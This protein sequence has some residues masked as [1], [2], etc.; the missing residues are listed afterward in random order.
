MLRQTRSTDFVLIHFAFKG[1]CKI[2]CKLANMDNHLNSNK[3][4]KN[5]AGDICEFHL[6]QHHHTKDAYVFA[7]VLSIT[8]IT[9]T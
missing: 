6:G 3:V 7:S 2:Y 9:L 5:D 4:F 1:G 8:K